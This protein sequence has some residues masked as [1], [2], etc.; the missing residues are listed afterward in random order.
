MQCDTGH[1]T[2]MELL[3]NHMIYYESRPS[4]HHAAVSFIVR[5]NAFNDIL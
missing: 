2:A 3:W 1:P 4:F 5:V